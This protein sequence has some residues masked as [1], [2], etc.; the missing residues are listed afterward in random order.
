MQVWERVNI[1]PMADHF[2]SLIVRHRPLQVL[3]ELLLQVSC[4]M[5][6]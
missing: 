3:Q 5:L 4:L 6:V 1:S 2:V